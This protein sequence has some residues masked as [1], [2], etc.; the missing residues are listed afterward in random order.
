VGLVLPFTG[1]LSTFGPSLDKSA[2]LA[3]KVINAA[4]KK[5]HITWASI[6]IVGSED[7]QTTPA[8]G[9]EAAKKLVSVDHA[10]VIVGSMA[11][12]V[13]LAIIQSVVIPN[14][15]LL[16]TPTS[17]DVSVTRL[18]NENHLVWRIYPSD[19][20]QGAV[21]AQ[22][23]GSAFG[24]HATINVGARNDAFGTALATI[25]QKNWKAGGGKI[26]NVVLYNPN[27]TS[28]DADAQKLA[29]GSPNGWMIADFP[30]TFEKMGPAL[31]RAGG[32]SPAKTFMTEAMDDNAELNK[33]G[34]PATDGLR[35]TAGSAPKGAT[36]QALETMFKQ[37]YPSA[38]YTGFEGTSFDAVVLAFLAALKADSSS[39][40]LVKLRLRPISGPSGKVFTWRQLPQAFNALVSGQSVH[41]VGAWGSVEWD[42]HG[43]P[44]SAIYVVW[45]HKNGQTTNVRTITF[46]T[47]K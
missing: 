33:I 20:L 39:P 43:D 6:K 4:L 29:S 11:S 31:V 13:T 19:A 2:L 30:I 40:N 1:D 21:L 24:K 26:G 5:D 38:S 12:S 3:A 45:Q 8:A 10:Q 17:S 32:W 15:I 28:F 42:S 23:M 35:G 37:N 9:V 7:D 14:H 18:A 25:F 22:V 36:A 34:A 27:E 41:Y 16:I 47:K 46:H 44:G